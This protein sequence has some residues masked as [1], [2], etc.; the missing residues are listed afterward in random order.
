MKVLIFSIFLILQIEAMITKFELLSQEKSVIDFSGVKLR[1]IN[2]T[3]R[4]LVGNFSLLENF[5]N[6][7]SI[8]MSLSKK[9]GRVK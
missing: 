9:Q 8:E 4:A 3:E 7:F 1:K 6:E 2:K 5:G